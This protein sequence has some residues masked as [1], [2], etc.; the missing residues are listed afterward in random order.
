VA[1]RAGL[2]GGIGLRLWPRGG[3]SAPRR[4]AAVILL[5]LEA[6]RITLARLA[7]QLGQ[8]RGRV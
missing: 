3:G 1:G 5:N 7:R 4:A 2:L 6:S 8:R